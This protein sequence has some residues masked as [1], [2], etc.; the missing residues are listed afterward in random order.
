[1][2]KQTISTISVIGKSITAARQQLESAAID[3]QAY[4]AAYNKSAAKKSLEAF[5]DIQKSAKELG[6][7]AIEASAKK[8]RL[9][10]EDALGRAKRITLTAEE[11]S[12]IQ[13]LFDRGFT[14][15]DI[16]ELYL[17]ENLEGTEWLSSTGVI[18]KKA[19]KSQLAKGS[20]E[21]AP[22]TNWT[23][24]TFATYLKRAYINK[25]AEVKVSIR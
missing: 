5:I 8:L 4:F 12:A 23:P 9:Q 10:I 7:T 6:D 3:F 1:M 15:S 18:L 20:A 11:K 13:S 19:T 25:T 21:Y 14:F 22:V 24:S 16:S 17:L 2:K